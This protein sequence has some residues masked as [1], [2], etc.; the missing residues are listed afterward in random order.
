MSTFSS[1]DSGTM[2]AGLPA[3]S[4]GL[5]LRQ[6][7]LLGC[8]R[9]CRHAWR[10][11]RTRSRRFLTVS[12]SASINSVLMTSMSRTG[13]IEPATCSTSG[14]SKHRT[15]WTIA[16]TSRMC[17]RNLLPSPSPWLAPFT[18]PAMSTNSMAAG[19]TTLVFAIR[20]SGRQ[21]VVGHRH[22]AHVGI[23]GAEGIVGRF[24]LAVARDGVEQGGL[25]DVGQSDDS[26]SQHVSCKDSA[27]ALH[28]DNTPADPAK[29]PPVGQV[30]R[31]ATLCALSTSLLFVDS[32]QTQSPFDLFL[33]FVGANI[34][35]T[36]LQVGREPARRRCRWAAALWIDCRG[37]HRRRGARGRARA[38]RL[39]ARSAVDRRGP[40]RPG[41]SA[42][43]GAWPSCSS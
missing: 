11:W 13:S 16:S 18:R 20:W 32:D 40:R 37:R 5:D 7:G 25:A 6:H 23:D 34:V 2:S 12:R 1:C 33:I 19:M 30:S 17:V 22:D 24:R 26:G 41:L 31:Y 9:A 39:A 21:P 35:A 28:Q 27:S 43:H 8:R 29:R 14:S 4:D 3:S 15:T 38:D 10:P 42:A 36:T